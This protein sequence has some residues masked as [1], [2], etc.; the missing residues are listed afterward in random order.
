MPNGNNSP[1][2]S[3]SYPGSSFTTTPSLEM[4]ALA[5]SRALNGGY[6]KSSTMW[7]QVTRGRY[8]S[9][10]MKVIGSSSAGKKDPGLQSDLD[11]MQSIYDVLGMKFS[12]GMGES[13]KASPFTK[14]SFAFPIGKAAISG[15]YE[16]K[17]SGLGLRNYDFNIGVSVPLDFKFG[18]RR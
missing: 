6:Q 5:Q 3:T 1:K 11:Y 2:T 16:R 14:G 10:K 7:N 4:R 12:G 17:R 13:F 9:G 15:S 8:P 18:K